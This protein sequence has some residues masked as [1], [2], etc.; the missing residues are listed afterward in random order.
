MTL[1]A[2]IAKYKGKQADF[3]NKP[4][5]YQCMDLYRLYM[6]EV[7][8]KPQTPGVIGAYQVLGSLPDNYF[9]TSHD[10][11]LPGD[12]IVWNETYA[13]N[14][15]IAIVVEASKNSLLVFEQ[16]NP[17]GSSC[18]LGLHIYKNISGWFRPKIM[19]RP[20]LKIVA[21]KITWSSE[22]NNQVA[23]LKSRVL[24]NSSGQIDLQAFI[25]YTNYDSIPYE[26]YTPV[27]KG[28]ARD[29]YKAN[30]T[31]KGLD[32]V[33]LLIDGND[34]Q[35]SQGT[36]DYA[37]FDDTSTQEMCVTAHKDFTTGGQGNPDLPEFVNFAEHELDH[38]FRQLTGQETPN[39]NPNL[40]HDYIGKGM[41][42]QILST[43]DYSKLNLALTKDK[44]QFYIDK[45]TTPPTIIAGLK[46]DEPSNLK[47]IGKEAGN[48]VPVKPDGSPD[49]DKMTYAGQIINN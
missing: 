40:V 27:L 37:Y 8:G 15:H 44:M 23:L 31:P 13:K 17:I 10:F 7:L 6:K 14:G 24:S 36:A 3:D 4:P 34:W 39:D 9:H 1:S 2:F 41:L 5:L 28:P 18:R 30:I 29:W 21:N 46:I 12:V 19:L 26:N 43:V 25:D 22:L 49:F 42:N 47:W 35:G 48:P 32:M 33:M 11:P 45:R 38:T 16:N 20:T